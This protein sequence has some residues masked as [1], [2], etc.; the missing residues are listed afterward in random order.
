MVPTINQIPRKP[1]YSCL[2]LGC[3][4]VMWTNFSTYPKSIHWC[5]WMLNVTL[6]VCWGNSCAWR[7]AVVW[8]SQLAAAQALVRLSLLEEDTAQSSG[9][10]D[11]LRMVELAP[12]AQKGGCLLISPPASC[13]CL[14]L[15][16]SPCFQILENTE[17]FQSIAK[18]LFALRNIK[19]YFLKVVV[20][21]DQ[22]DLK[23]GGPQRERA[24]TCLLPLKEVLCDTISAAPCRVKLYPWVISSNK[25]NFING[26]SVQSCPALPVFQAEHWTKTFERKGYKLIIKF[27]FISEFI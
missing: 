4:V 18:S 11:A 25:F 12:G 23:V 8:P 13:C 5:E 3:K 24:K 14:A 7:R 15:G 20:C 17:A 6:G 19:G 1:I 9:S 26:F 27:G 16:S 10:Q 21:V 22:R 2:D